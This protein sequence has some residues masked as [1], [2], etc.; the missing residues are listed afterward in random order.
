VSRQPPTPSRQLKSLLA[1]MRQCWWAFEIIFNGFDFFGRFSN[2]LAEAF[3]DAFLN[4]VLQ[5]RL[6]EGENAL[7]IQRPILTNS[8]EIHD[9][10]RGIP[11]HATNS[12]TNLDQFGLIPDKLCD[13]FRGIPNYATNSATNLD[14]F[15]PIPTNF[16]TNFA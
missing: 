7:G 16:A 5:F 9:Q 1:M 3:A 2:M 15:G 8:D 4:G 12:A 13:Q 10:F 6:G 14:Q 11:N